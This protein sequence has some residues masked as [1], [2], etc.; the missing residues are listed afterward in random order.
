MRFT[1]GL[2]TMI[3]GFRR[4]FESRVVFLGTHSSSSP[5]LP[6][7]LQSCSPSSSPLPREI[8]VFV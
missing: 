8:E 6:Q 5:A 7:Q 2:T 1:L 4:R 3:R